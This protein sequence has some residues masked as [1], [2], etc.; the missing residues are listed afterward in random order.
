M[1]VRLAPAVV[2]GLVVPPVVRV[3]PTMRRR[4]ILA[5]VEQTAVRDADDL[6][7]VVLMVV[8]IV[9]RRRPAATRYK[10]SLLRR[11]VVRERRVRLGPVLLPAVIDDADGDR[12]G[13]DGRDGEDREE[14]AD[15]RLSAELLERREKRVIRQ[16]GEVERPTAL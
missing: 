10:Q 9:V 2:I 12:Q 11:V 16:P 1:R 15:E 7:D 8:V 6:A 13:K 5:E 14:F 3:V 4:G